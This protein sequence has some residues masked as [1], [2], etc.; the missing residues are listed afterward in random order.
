[1]KTD[2]VLFQQLLVKIK[3]T[4]DVGVIEKWNKQNNILILISDK[5]ELILKIQLEIKELIKLK[6][7]RK[8]N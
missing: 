4:I 2:M 8:Y 6:K 7:L 3:V 5:K 1:M